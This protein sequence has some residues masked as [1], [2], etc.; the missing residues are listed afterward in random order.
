MRTRLVA[1]AVIL[2]A[3]GAGTWLILQTSRPAAIVFGLSVL[4]LSLTAFLNRKK[5]ASAT[6]DGK[7]TTGSSKLDKM[8]AGTVA[9]RQSR[10]MVRAEDGEIRG[11]PGGPG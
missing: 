6:S 3:G 4:L 11:L 9:F 8:P 2:L 5:P 7:H 1:F 10:A